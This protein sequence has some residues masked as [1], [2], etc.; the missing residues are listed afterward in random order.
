M[1]IGIAAVIVRVC[2]MSN[3]TRHAGLVGR[4]RQRRIV[5]WWACSGALK[6][7]PTAL[8]SEPSAARVLF[9]RTVAFNRGDADTFGLGNALAYYAY[10]IAHQGDYAEATTLAEEALAIGVREDLPWTQQIALLALGLIVMRR[11]DRSAACELFERSLVQSQRLGDRLYSA[12]A[13]SYLGLIDLREQNVERAYG[14]LV[15][16]LEFGWA[17]RSPKAIA[18]ALEGLACLWAIK[19]EW[20]RATQL[21][22]SIEMIYVRRGA[23]AAHFNDEL[24]MPY[25]RAARTKLGPQGFALVLAKGQEL[26]LDEA[27]ALASE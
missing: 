1:S 24:H 7:R 3:L 9:E 15:K 25:V 4:L 13:L 19:G 12:A 26:S 21:F 11:H 6:S 20:E 5:W 8:K 2:V 14:R 23:T 10:V 16:A 27:Y 17:I 22:G 18:L